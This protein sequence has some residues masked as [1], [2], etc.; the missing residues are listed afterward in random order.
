[1]Q[2]DPNE[3]VGSFHSNQLQS[4]DSPFEGQGAKPSSIIGSKI[5][6]PRNLYDV[7]V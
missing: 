6:S 2:S 7:T 3:M 5:A 4:I 1:M